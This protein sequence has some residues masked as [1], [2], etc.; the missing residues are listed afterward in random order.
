MCLPLGVAVFTAVAAGLSPALPG[1]GPLAG[2]P[3]AAQGFSVPLGLL[4]LRPALL[5]RARREA[6]S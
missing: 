2:P 5:W 4:F 6:R 1:R 3:S